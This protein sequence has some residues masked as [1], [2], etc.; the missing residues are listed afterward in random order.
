[1]ERALVN[2]PSVRRVVVHGCDHV[3]R[4][5]HQQVADAAHSWLEELR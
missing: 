3:Y 1:M 4:G 2:A 5:R